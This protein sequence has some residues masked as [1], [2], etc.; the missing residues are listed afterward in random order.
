MRRVLCLLCYIACLIPSA[1]GQDFATKFMEQC[2]EKD[3]M[4]CQTVSP[5]MMEKVMDILADPDENEDEEVQEYL[6]SKLKS[7]RIITADRHAE[8]LFRKAESL[9]EKNKNR[10]SPLAEDS[11]GDHNRI[12]VR[13]HDDVVR[14][15]VMLQLSPGKDLLTI[16]DLTGEMY[17]KFMKLLS[18]GELKDD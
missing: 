8:K 16:V 13:R 17:E 6:L 12:F 1:W 18:S 11:A 7:A 3:K 2:G 4:E 14:E 10:F 9:I 15:L 5:K